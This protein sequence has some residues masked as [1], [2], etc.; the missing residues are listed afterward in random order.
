MTALAQKLNEEK[1]S[2]LLEK[3]P[4]IEERKDRWGKVRLVS[5]EIASIT[6]DVDIYHSCG[7][8]SDSVLYASPYTNIDGIKLFTNPCQLIIGNRFEFGCGDIR[9]D[10]WEKTLRDVG[11]SEVV[12]DKVGRY[13]DAN[14]PISRYSDED[15]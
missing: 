12:I 5:K 10:N 11:V 2:K 3:F 6:T 9:D 1:V 7:C 15:E 8:C 13:L 14:Q 4:D